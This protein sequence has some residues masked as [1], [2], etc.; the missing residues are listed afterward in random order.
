MRIRRTKCVAVSCAILAVCAAT[1]WAAAGYGVRTF[2]ISRGVGAPWGTAVDKA[3]NLW[4][5]EPGCDF[6][7]T[8]SAG[9]RPGQIG[10]L[11]L[12][13][14]RIALYTLPRAPGNQPIFVAFDGRGK[15]WF[16]TPNNDRIG[17]FD[18]VRRKFVGQWRVSAGSAPWDLAFARGKIWYAEFRGSAVGRFD[19]ATHAHRDFR[20]PSADSEPYG[21][22][23]RAGLV[24]FTENGSGVDRVAV[25]DTRRHDAIREYPIVLPQSG[26]PHMITL[27]PSGHPWWSE[28]FSGTIATLDPARAVPGSC[29]RT[30]GTC[31]GVRR[32]TVPPATGCTLGSHA[33]GVLFDQTR[34]LLWL[35]DSLSGRVGSLNPRT[36]RFDLIKLHDCNAHPHDGL[37]LGRSG[38]VWFDEEFANGL[39]ELVP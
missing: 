37:A 18:P 7:S 8:C 28:G 36:G 11:K 26:T 29:G 25:L 9:S 38:N 10:E 19:P 2:R 30:A 22:A 21:I 39:G 1:A 23:V 5:A 27:G 35:D 6:S 13:S 34:H 24:W 12:A 31:R 20:T 4:F 14:H 3:G 15:L 33:S 17:E 16:T 32:F